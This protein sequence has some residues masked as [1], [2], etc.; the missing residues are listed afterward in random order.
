MPRGRYQQKQWDD[1]QT[2]IL[3]ALEQLSRERGFAAVTMDDVAAAVGI[4]KATLYQ[5]F[6]SKD[7]MVITLLAQHEERFI[8]QVETTADQPPVARLL[9]TMRILMEGHVSPLRGLV[10]L[11]RDEIL[12]IFRSNT[13]LMTRHDQIIL[14]LT[15]IVPQ[16]QADGSIAPD[17]APHTIIS[18]MIALST[19]SMGD[20]EPPECNRGQIAQEGYAGQM[21]KLF[22]RSLRP[23]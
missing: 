4:S 2:A 18:A 10:S 17:L 3:V 15:G 12:P 5:H 6:E 19:V 20:Y 8:A 11:G 16:G 9:D 22:E 1:R 13:D 7:A 14:L 23:G 21:L